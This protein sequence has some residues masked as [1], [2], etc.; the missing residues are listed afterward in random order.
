MVKVEQLG[1]QEEGTGAPSASYGLNSAPPTPNKVPL[2]SIDYFHPC[3]PQ[4]P[5]VNCE[6]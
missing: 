5:P 2:P 3:P 4:A 6:G 1:G